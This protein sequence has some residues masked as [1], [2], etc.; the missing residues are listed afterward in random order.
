MAERVVFLH[1]IGVGPESWDAQ[2]AALPEVYEGYAP[3]IPG[4]VGDAAGF[5]LS[6]AAADVI[7]DL[8]RRGVERAHLC[9][10]SLGAMLALQIAVDHP[11]RVASLTLS[12][13]QVHPSRALMVLQS[14][15]MRLLP[16]RMVAPDGLSK[17]GTLAILDAMAR[18]DFRP[19]L[20]GV[21]TPTLVLCGSNDKPNLPAARSLATGIPGACLRVIDGGGDELNTDRPAEFSTELA[22]FLTGLEE[23]APL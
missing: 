3:R 9:G 5:T 19:H 4:L 11:E 15:I 14:G 13:G 7:A 22:V 17:K 18:V 10:L 21:M 12:G 8:D 23:R 6:T 1:G 2:L 16:E 20:A